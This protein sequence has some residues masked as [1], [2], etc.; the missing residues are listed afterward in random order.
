VNTRLLP[1]LITAPE[2]V[3]A[4]AT[5]AD[6]SGVVYIAD[7]DSAGTR[8]VYRVLFSTPGV[9]TKLNPAFAATRQA[10][11]IA[12][13]PDSGSVIY[14]A[15][16]TSVTAVELYRAFFASAGGSTKLNGVLVSG[17]NVDAFTIR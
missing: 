1:G 5:I 13:T 12:V 4:V 16:Q 2:A 9:S 7:Q 14:L 6:S 15:N 11:K 8:E 17:G 10:Q 3:Y